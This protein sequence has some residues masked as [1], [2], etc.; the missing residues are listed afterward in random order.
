MLS[1]SKFTQHLDWFIAVWGLRWCNFSLHLVL[2][3]VCLYF[4][5]CVFVFCCS[6]SV[7]FLFLPALV[8]LRGLL[9]SDVAVVVVV[10]VVFAGSRRDWPGISLLRSLVF[11]TCRALAPDGAGGTRQC[12]RSVHVTVRCESPSK[13]FGVLQASGWLRRRQVWFRLWHQ[14]EHT[15][16]LPSRSSGIILHLQIKTNQDRIKSLCIFLAAVCDPRSW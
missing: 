10:V 5:L 2:F 12:G 4:G 1:F 3:A 8:A 6:L 7:C 14:S 13:A 16:H 15:V 9:L 11:C